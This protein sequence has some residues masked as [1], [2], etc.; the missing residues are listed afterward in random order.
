M[1]T[2]PKLEF[3]KFTLNHK[4]EKFKTF[5]DFAI[6]ELSGEKSISNQDAF[7]LCF[8]KF[9]SAFDNDYAKDTK[10]KKAITVISDAKI[11]LH[12]DKKPTFNSAKSIIQGVINGGPY[13]KNR[14]VSDIGDKNDISTLTSNK[15]VMFYY[16]IFV[17]LPPDH[18]QGFFMIHSNGSDETVTVI[19]RDYITNLFKGNNFNKP[20][21]EAFCPKSFQDEF[22]KGAVIKSISFNTPVIDTMHTTDAISNLLKEYNLKIEAIPKNKTISI[23]SAQ[24]VYNFFAKKLFNTGNKGIELEKFSTKKLHTENDLTKTPKVFEWNTKDLDF[25]P[26]V[27]LNGRVTMVSD[28]TPDFVE[29]KTLCSNIF[30]DDILKELRPDLYVTKAK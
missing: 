3:Y 22:M 15:T 14:I 23:E 18:N 17:Y 30:E 11:N 1:A 27:H 19:F 21:S 28:E 10:R 8:T 20:I 7:K 12:L 5:K 24:N 29:L 25:V 4:K 6:E 9:M 16:Y 2:N 13:G 26:V